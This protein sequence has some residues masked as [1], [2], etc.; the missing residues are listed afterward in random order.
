MRHKSSETIERL[1]KLHNSKITP[2]SIHD[3]GFPEC[4]A[5]PDFFSLCI[6]WNVD[7]A[8]DHLCEWLKQ[9]PS[10]DLA[11]LDCELR[12]RAGMLGIYS[13]SFDRKVPLMVRCLMTCHP[14]G[15]VREK[16]IRSLKNNDSGEEL[17]FLLLRLNDW[18]RP[19]QAIA[20]NLL[21][22]RLKR[23]SYT[24]H[25]LHCIYLVDRLRE[26][27]RHS[28]QAMVKEIYDYIARGDAADVLRVIEQGDRH[29]SVAAFNLF[30]SVCPDDRQ[31]L[32]Q[33]ALR[34]V[35][36]RLHLKCTSKID[37]LGDTE[38]RA[39]LPLLLQ[40]RPPLRAAT[41]RSYCRR[42]PANQVN[43]LK[44]MLLDSGASVR[45]AVVWILRKFDDGFDA[46]Q[47]YREI[48]RKN[49]SVSAI[50]ALGQFGDKSD[51]DLLYTLLEGDNTHRVRKAALQSLVHLDVEGS[52][53]LLFQYLPQQ[54][55]AKLTTKL[56]TNRVVAADWPRLVEIYTKGNEIVR[57]SVKNLLQHL[58][59]EDRAFALMHLSLSFCEFTDKLNKF[60]QTSNFYCARDA[61]KKEMISLYDG[62]KA[63]FA[64]EVRSSLELLFKGWR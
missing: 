2:A 32:V 52:V 19:V 62:N 21:K 54:G 43:F 33:S 22:E 57:R 39:V 61:R 26:C 20:T 11:W 30:E 36:P 59:D 53:D 31:E 15:K 27:W 37:V 3:F 42:F 51:S 6:D 12:E 60:L 35:H 55:F 24:G 45:D 56:L 47:Y 46:G 18:A 10:T 13:V 63:T 48:L 23:E 44:S 1:E 16:A 7:Y 29:A 50:I 4:G 64:G 40:A 9:V 38:F 5:L 8:W 14:S 28:H 25:F 34:S 41:I 17:P 49:L 58:P